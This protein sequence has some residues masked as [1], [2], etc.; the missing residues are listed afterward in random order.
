[1][2]PRRVMLALSL[3][4]LVLAMACG[5]TTPPPDTPAP[6]AIATLPPQTPATEVS[7]TAEAPLV[8]I[9]YFSSIY[10]RYDP[11]VWEVFD[12]TPDG[13]SNQKGEPIQRL[14]HRTIPGCLLHEN[15]GRGVPPS[16]EL[17]V[18][19]RVIGSLEY[20]VEEWTDTAVR[21]Q[22]LIVYQY[23][24]GES[25]IGKRIELVIDEQPEA[26]IRSAEDV[27]ALSADLI[28]GSP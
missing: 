16:W 13:Q 28:S 1:M 17:Q 23:P 3:L 26:C 11:Q 8:Q 2:G 10:V 27:L 5:S 24:P 25:V 15:L 14:Q 21:K 19:D 22:V 4:V 7:Q 12:E 20:R 18:T 6:P 9:G